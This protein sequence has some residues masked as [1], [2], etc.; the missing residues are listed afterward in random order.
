MVLTTTSFHLFGITHPICTP[1]LIR[2]LETT[3]AHPTRRK[4]FISSPIWTRGTVLDTLLLGFLKNIFSSHLFPLR[5]AKWTPFYR[6]NLSP[7]LVSTG[8]DEV[9]TLFERKI[10]SLHLSA[11]GTVVWTPKMLKK[12][13]TL[14]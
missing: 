4:I 8:R 2:N 6:K 12:I 1:S 3:F 13:Y 14:H 10:Y 11:M 9:H 7:S 5:A